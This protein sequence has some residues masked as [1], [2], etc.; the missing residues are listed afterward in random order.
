MSGDERK[1]DKTIQQLLEETSIVDIVVNYEP[2]EQ[3]KRDLAERG[4]KVYM[5]QLTQAGKGLYKR[6]QQIAGTAKSAADDVIHFAQKHE[7]NEEQEREER[8][9]R[10]DELTKGH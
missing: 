10:F 1:L 6:L 5:S 4:I 3:V 2:S 9:K 7:E 8:R